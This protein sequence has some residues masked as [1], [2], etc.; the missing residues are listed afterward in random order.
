MQNV[1]ER[2]INA[3]GRDRVITS[4]DVLRKYSRDFWPLLMMR[5]QVFNEELPM[6]LAVVVPESVN[7]VSLALRII[8]EGNDV[9][10]VVV[11]GGGSSVTGAS[12]G[13]GS[14]IIDMSKLNRVIDINTYDSL[15]TVEA[16]ARLRDVETRLNEVGY[17]LRHIPQSFNYA[18]IGGLI[19]TMSSG[20]Y[21]TLY[22]NIED[23]VINLEVVLPNG[24]ITWLRSN[25]VP[26]ASTGPS[27]KYLFIGSE[28]MLGVI[29]KAVLRIVPLP[30]STIYGAYSF[31]TL[32]QG[33]EALREL[34]IKR[35]IPA[36]ARLYDDNE[37]ALRFSIN[38][39]LLI[40]SF[41][42]YYDD[43]VQALWRRA[44]E[45]IKSHG[46]EYVGSKYFED[47][48]RTRFNVEEEI[49]M[50]KMY[51]LWFDTIEVSTIWSRVNQL[52]RDFRESLLR[53]NG[54]VGVMAHISHLYI[55]GACIYFTVLFKPNVNTYWELWSRAMEVTLRNGGSISHHHGIGIV[56]SRWLGRELGNA[57]NILRTIKTALDN[58]GVLNTKSNMF[59][60]TER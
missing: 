42:G 14:I 34:M 19:A 24:E 31:K 29:T 57:L 16:G 17:S 26:R 2:L 23:M 1:I 4:N 44:D 33:V 20:Q 38:E 49:E 28:G 46:G 22:G 40:I 36:I 18:T 48:L 43:I 3:L 30:T 11:Y 25:N 32:E 39:P 58:K 59:F 54:V 8:N 60:T 15:V 13:A 47:W 55:N 53:V 56:R 6:P 45:I 51:G 35:V 9:V 5:E 21:S 10:P 52:Y 27:L 7:D 50:I 37:A 41:E 12:Y